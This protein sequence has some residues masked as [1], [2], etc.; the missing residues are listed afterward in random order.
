MADDGF[1]PEGGA[2]RHLSCRERTALREHLIACAN[3]ERQRLLRRAAARIAGAL[4][5]AWRRANELYIAAMRRL[6]VRHR[7][8]EA[9]RQL[10]GMTDRELRDIGISRLEI[11]AA[12]RSD[13]AWPRG[14][15]STST[16][17]STQGEN[18]AKGLLDRPRLCS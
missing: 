15:Q 7:R 6:V 13:A 5:H 17:R 1:N 18:R 9:L 16:I 2:V 4:R 3:E 10:A 14:D 11:S 8:M 12:A